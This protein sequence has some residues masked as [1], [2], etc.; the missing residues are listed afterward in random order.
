MMFV[1]ADRIREG[2]YEV[3]APKPLKAEKPV[4]AIPEGFDAIKD[5]DIPF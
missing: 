1:S 4:Q 2:K 5:E 3:P